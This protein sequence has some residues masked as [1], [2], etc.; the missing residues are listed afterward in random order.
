[1]RYAQS[2]LGQWMEPSGSAFGVAPTNEELQHQLIKT[3]VVAGSAYLFSALEGYQYTLPKDDKGN[4]IKGEDGKPLPGVVG[5]EIKLAGK[6]PLNLVVAAAAHAAAFYDAGDSIGVDADYL[7]AFASGALA[8]WTTNRGH[9]MGMK[10]RKDAIVAEKR[11]ELNND[12]YEGKYTQGK[13]FDK[14]G[15]VQFGQAP[16][17]QPYTNVARRYGNAVSPWTMGG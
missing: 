17:L 12:K 14:T 9:E 13:D 11:K 2:D 15:E 6:V 1:M 4:V 7:H 5:G 3:G 8:V 16:R 10:M